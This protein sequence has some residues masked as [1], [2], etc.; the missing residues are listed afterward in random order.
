[1]THLEAMQWQ[2]M[3]GG[4]IRESPSPR[5][6]QP[7]RFDVRSPIVANAIVILRRAL[8]AERQARMA[9][10][11]RLRSVLEEVARMRVD[12]TPAAEQI[13]EVPAL[14]AANEVQQAIIDVSDNEEES[15]D[16]DG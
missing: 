12:P 5:L 1:M 3:G 13:I 6:V 7:P 10:E 9:A 2:I 11:A 4:V 8:N 16:Y 14:P 15:E